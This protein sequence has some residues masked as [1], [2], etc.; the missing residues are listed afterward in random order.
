MQI[1]KKKGFRKKAQKY[2]IDDD[3]YLCYKK[4]YNNKDSSSDE[5]EDLDNKVFAKNYK[6]QKNINIIRNIHDEINHRCSKDTKNE[7]KKRKII[8]RGYVN[9][10]KYILSI[11][12]LL[13]YIKR[14]F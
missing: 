13:I 8:Y 11:D 7:M 3:G 1:Q 2:I 10:I 12:V 14:L 4:Y 6:N 5:S 9:N